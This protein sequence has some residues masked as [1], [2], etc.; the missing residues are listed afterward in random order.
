MAKRKRQVKRKPSVSRLRLRSRKRTQTVQRKRKTHTPKRTPKRTEK[1]TIKKRIIRK[2]RMKKQKPPPKQKPKHDFLVTVNFLAT[3]HRGSA[4]RYS[5]SLLV[6]APADA[7]PRMI[8]SLARQEAPRAL[9][10]LI[11]D[12]SWSRAEISKGPKTKRKRSE[13]R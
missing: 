8:L 10:N 12:S 9:R 5:R 1:R 2:K 11:A 4:H 6:P 13:E 7:T 3:D